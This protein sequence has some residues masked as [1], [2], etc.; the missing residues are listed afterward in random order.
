[1][2]RVDRGWEGGFHSSATIERMGKIDL[3]R[4]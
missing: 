4:K 2:L 3:S 1:M